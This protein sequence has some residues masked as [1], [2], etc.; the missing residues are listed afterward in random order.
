MKAVLCPGSD[1]D[2][3]TFFGILR[4]LQAQD[5]QAM[6]GMRTYFQAFVGNFGDKFMAY[7]VWATSR[8]RR[9][10]YEDALIFRYMKVAWCAGHVRDVGTFP[11]ISGLFLGCGVQAMSRRHPGCRRE[12]A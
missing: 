4:H 3:G 1:S 9:G 5:V 12:A 7:G 6:S 8:T 10:R 2:V 11:S